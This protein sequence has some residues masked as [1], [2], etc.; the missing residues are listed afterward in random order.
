V[1]DAERDIVDHRRRV[2]ALGQVPQLDRRHPFNSLA[3]RCV[4]ARLDR[5]IHM[6]TAPCLQEIA[7]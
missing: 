1:V 3:S 5:A 6:W 7:E 2:I 4:I